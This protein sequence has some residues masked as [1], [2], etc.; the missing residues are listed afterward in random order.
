LKCT[1][2]IDGGLHFGLAAFLL[3]EKAVG[4]VLGL[5]N[6]T[7]ENLFSVVLDGPKLGDLLV[8]QFLALSLLFFKFLLFTLL[9]HVLQ[10][11][12]LLVVFFNFK[13]LLLISQPEGFL[14]LHLLTVDLSEVCAVLSNLLEA[15][16]LLMLFA[17]EVFFSLALD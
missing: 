16:K 11:L 2:A 6:L 13:R 15:G 9:A 10:A 8:N 3:F 12:A 4:L 5:G 1:A 14:L 17:L 7:V